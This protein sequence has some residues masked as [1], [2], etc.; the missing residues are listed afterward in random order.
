MKKL[1]AGNWKMNLAM[2]A[3]PAIAKAAETADC[4]VLICPPAS[5]LSAVNAGRGAAALGG[6]DC[7]A[8]PKGAFTGEIAAS[9]LA[10]LGARY[11]IL[12]HSERR[13]L[14]GENNAQIG[15]KLKAA[16]H[17]NLVPILCV[18]EDLDQREAGKEKEVV[19]KQITDAL[20]AALSGDLVIAYEPVWAIGTGKT[21]K[22]DQ[23][24]DM[25]DFIRATLSGVYGPDRAA[26]IPLLYGGSVK[27]DNAADLF[28][29]TNVNG[30][31]VGGA[32][33][34]AEAFIPIIDA[35]SAS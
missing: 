3:V 18:G 35:L 25:H 17:A 14:F 27:A 15:A 23:V 28:A 6:Q 12:G 5:H 13:A 24:G 22:P 4:D 32:S 26:D 34:T 30:A 8:E 20:P 21:A 2:A 31:L 7:H 29:L 10:D 19:E 16:M 11:V 9:M 1:V 33:L